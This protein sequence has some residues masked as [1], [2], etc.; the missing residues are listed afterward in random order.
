MG[1]ESALVTAGLSSTTASAVVTGVITSAIGA[2]VTYATAPKPQKQ[3]GPKSLTG[4]D[5][6]PGVQAEKQVDRNLMLNKNTIASAGAL[7]GNSSTL[8]T[9]SQGVNPG[10]L[11]LGSSTLLGQ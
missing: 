1:I 2:A 8:L 6:P 4:A 3:E 11:N 5:K 9:G 7:A 10:S